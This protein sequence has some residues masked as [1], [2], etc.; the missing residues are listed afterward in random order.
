MDFQVS[1]VVDEPQFAKF[2]HEST[3]TRPCGADHLRK[4]LL[5]DFRYDRLWPPLL[6]KIG[7][8]EKQPRQAFLARIEKLVNQILFNS[9]VRSEHLRK[10][11]L[12]MEHAHDGRFYCAHLNRMESVQF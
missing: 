9:G 3:H 2:V 8:Q 11:W 10:Y 7:H 5:A 4:R 1:I 6:A 12:V